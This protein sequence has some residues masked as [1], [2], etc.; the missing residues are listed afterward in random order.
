MGKGAWISLF[1]LVFIVLFFIPNLICFF[2]RPQERYRSGNILIWLLNLVG[3]AAAL[4]TGV[5]WLDSRIRGFYS[6]EEFLCFWLGSIGL[7]LVNWVVWILY[8]VM[9]RPSRGGVPGEEKS[10]GIGRRRKILQIVLA[11]LPVCLFFLHGIAQRY[12][13]LMICSAIFA[14][15][16]LLT[17][18]EKIR[19][20]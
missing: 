11:V 1:A 10:A 15:G 8:L 2:I 20:A 16:H 5:F 18:W 13:A 19:K 3:G 4:F 7:I 12:P 17:A 9:T 14:V 6:V